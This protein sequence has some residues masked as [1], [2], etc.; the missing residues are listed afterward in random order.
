[1]TRRTEP[2][3]AP[4]SNPVAANPSDDTATPPLR[5]IRL[6]EVKGR[7]G[8]CTSEIYKQMREGR[9]PRPINLTKT[10]VAWLESAVVDWQKS[11]K[12]NFAKRLAIGK[13]KA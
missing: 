5:F 8:L 7:V 10:R 11:R 1:M 13:Q 4:A 6:P 3:I 12:N 9:F 2:R